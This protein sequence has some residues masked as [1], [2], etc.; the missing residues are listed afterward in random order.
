MHA[1]TYRATT[2]LCTLSD[3][4]VLK[5]MER[6][7]RGFMFGRVRNCVWNLCFA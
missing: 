1:E 3:V 6:K 7:R 2:M 4:R 5:K